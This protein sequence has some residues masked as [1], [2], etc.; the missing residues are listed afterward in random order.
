MKKIGKI[1]FDCSVNAYSNPDHETL[2]NYSEYFFQN[3]YDAE[4]VNK[5]VN[6]NLLYFNLMY[7]FYKFDWK[8]NVSKLNE[9]KFKNLSFKL[10]HAYR[11]NYYHN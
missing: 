6:G 5:A 8:N 7:C 1:S 11:L 4:L 2:N 10:Q 9:Q 3:A